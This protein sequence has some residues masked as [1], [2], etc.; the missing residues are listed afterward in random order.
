[1]D[2]CIYISITKKH[3]QTIKKMSRWWVVDATIIRHLNILSVEERLATWVHATRCILPESAER[4]RK[5]TYG[6]A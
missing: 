6:A 1:M 4:E 3:T 5:L 2:T